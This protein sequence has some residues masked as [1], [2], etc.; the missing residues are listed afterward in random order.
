MKDAAKV[1]LHV[2][3]AYTILAALV[4]GDSNAGTNIEKYPE[5]FAMD[6]YYKCMKNERNLYCTG[7]L[8]LIP[9]DHTSEF[10]S[11][12]VKRSL[13][14]SNFNRTIVY[15]KLCIPES[16]TKNYAFKK[17]FI[18]N[19][20]NNELLSHNLSSQVFDIQC[21]KEMIFGMSNS[22]IFGISA[23]Y[24]G[25]VMIAT[26]Y[27]GVFLRNRRPIS[28]DKWIRCF[29]LT[30]SWK[31]ITQ[32]RSEDFENLQCMQGIRTFQTL[33][34]V[35]GHVMLAL[36]QKHI[37]NTGEIEY[38][39]KTLLY[40]CWTTFFM[41]VMQTYL[42]MSSWL[43]TN[44]IMEIFKQNREFS[45][46]DAVLLLVHR[47]ARF[48]PVLFVMIFIGIPSMENGPSI[49]ELGNMQ[50]HACSKNWWATLLFVTNFINPYEVCNLVMWSLSIDTQFYLCA[51]IFFYVIHKYG[52]NAE[53]F[54]GLMFLITYAINA[55]QV[56]IFD[57]GTNSP[58]SLKLLTHLNF[59]Y[60]GKIPHIYL[61]FWINSSSSI[62]G[63]LF[64]YRYFCRK[65]SKPKEKSHEKLLYTAFIALPLL[66]VI[67]SEIELN[68]LWTVLLT[69]L[70]KPLFG[71]GIAIGIYG[72]YRN[73][74]KGYSKLLCENKFAVFLGNFT[75][76]VY[77]FHFIPVFSRNARSTYTLVLNVPVLIPA[78]I[79]DSI[80]SWI[81]GVIACVI[82]EQPGIALKN[83]ILPSMKKKRQ[84]FRYYCNENLNEIGKYRNH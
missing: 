33:I 72:M 74:I 4:M 29:S 82:L 19:T 80:K 81:I 31:K 68:K 24:I 58:L 67:I 11:E 54:L 59:F 7:I 52:L 44:Q 40:Q 83:L 49:F 9:K 60:D 18:E 1:Q 79:K 64:G 39:S 8:K 37:R 16:F 13:H 66:A 22:S 65:D 53:I 76:C 62:I 48:W 38:Y 50:L 78:I 26:L 20:T 17:K 21:K 69:P 2:F 84:S 45:L 27:E 77:V 75:F 42:V 6:N 3:G 55:W 35:S 46:R 12:I 56:H 61:G 32:S 73:Y 36:T 15:R 28:I 5:L 14:S 71:Y 63:M 51:I 47:C 10:W 43:C 41:L 57:L 34:I 25:I 30:S 70:V 23:I